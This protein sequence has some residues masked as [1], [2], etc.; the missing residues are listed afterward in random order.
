[1]A[2]APHNLPLPHLDARHMGARR[3]SVLTDEALLS[4]VGVRVA[5]T[6]KEGGVS[7]GPYASLNLGS[8][9]GDDLDA[10]LLNRRLLME[11]LGAPELPVL[12]PN[13]V[14]G[15]TVVGVDSSS[16]GNLV[17]CQQRAQAG[18]D[19]LVVAADNVAALLCFADC[20][21][22]V[23][24]SPSGRF[25]VCHAG[26]RGV[27]AGVVPSALKQ[28][29]AYDGGDQHKAASQCNVYIGPH[30]AGE[31]FEVGAEVV[32][33]FVDAFGDSC[34]VDE[35]HISMARALR[36]SLCRSGVVPERIA[37]AGM[38]TVCHADTYYSYRAS[39]GTCGRHGAIAFRKS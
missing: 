11:A 5:F 13:Q 32:Q 22:V 12:V 15:S 9:V 19:A 37:D 39:G 6:S 14:H 26:W 3:I 16:A 38:C 35:R 4:A 18:S 23:I 2:C 24:V 25:A 21:P 30:I 8:H 27:V 36:V 7:E 31:C 17:E 10:V 34:V 1:M 20:T 33:A 29:I 28:L